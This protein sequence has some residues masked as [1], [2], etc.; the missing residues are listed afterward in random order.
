[1]AG[2]LLQEGQARTYSP[3]P[4]NS[5]IAVTS[6]DRPTGSAQL[7]TTKQSEIRRA[8]P[9]QR[10]DISARQ[11]DIADKNHAKKRMGLAMLFSRTLAEEG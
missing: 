5:S 9:G 2:I 6:M 3:S 7:M 11:K 4:R 10:A 8:T 1:M